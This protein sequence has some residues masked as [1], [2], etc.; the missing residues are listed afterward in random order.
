MQKARKYI[1]ISKNT[2]ES[3]RSLGT[4]TDSFDSVI[5][6]LLKQ[7]QSEQLQKVSR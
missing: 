7:Q 3:L 6:Q 5:T 1:V 2:Y 4:V